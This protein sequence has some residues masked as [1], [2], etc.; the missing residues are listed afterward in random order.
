MS[1]QT[2]NLREGHPPQARGA[3]RGAPA[4]VMGRS[5]GAQR[6]GEGAGLAAGRF[7][8]SAKLGTLRYKSGSGPSHCFSLG[9]TVFLNE[10][11]SACWPTRS[12]SGTFIK[13]A[14]AS[15]SAKRE[16]SSAI[17]EGD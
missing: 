4:M 9:E 1:D 17:F 14:L 7:E 8:T 12:G 16:Q 3:A 13:T 15:G 2:G 11:R 6:A 10:W 5:G